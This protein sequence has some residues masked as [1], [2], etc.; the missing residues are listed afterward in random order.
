MQFTFGDT[1]EVHL[2]DGSVLPVNEKDR[3]EEVKSSIGPRMKYGHANHKSNCPYTNGRCSVLNLSFLSV[4][5]KHKY[6]TPVETSFKLTFSAHWLWS[7]LSRKLQVPN[8]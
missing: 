8:L 6:T 5:K 3:R 4:I 7:E 2:L 1:I